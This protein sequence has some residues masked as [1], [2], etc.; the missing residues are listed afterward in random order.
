MFGIVKLLL[1]LT[2]PLSYFH[3]MLNVLYYPVFYYCWFCFWM[4]CII[5]VPNGSSTSK[6]VTCNNCL[7]MHRNQCLGTLSNCLYMVSY[8]TAETSTSWILVEDVQYLTQT[9]DNHDLVEAN[10]VFG[11]VSLL[12]R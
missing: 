12:N 1:M 3:D 9:D 7:C 10:V 4:E 5:I 11:L 8:V 2:L 6:K